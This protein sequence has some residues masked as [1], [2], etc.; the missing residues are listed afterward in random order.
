M[1][2]CLYSDMHP[3]LPMA[4]PCPRRHGESFFTRRRGG[5][6]VHPARPEGMP[7][8]FERGVHRACD[9]RGRHV[10]GHDDAGRLSPAAG[11]EWRRDSGASASEPIRARSPA[12]HAANPVRGNTALSPPIHHYAAAGFHQ[13]TTGIAVWVPAPGYYYDIPLQSYAH[14]QPSA[15][16]GWQRARPAPAPTGPVRP[17]PDG[18]PTVHTELYWYP[19]AWAGTEEHGALMKALTRQ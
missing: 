18:K 15:A 6:S 3:S 11:R 12:G 17:Q 10:D 2:I 7:E 4:S 1:L 19:R 9:A 8:A 5:S 16:T 14:A 13:T